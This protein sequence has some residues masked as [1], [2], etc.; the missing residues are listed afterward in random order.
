MSKKFTI[1]V[2][3]AAIG[4]WVPYNKVLIILL[5]IYII[6]IIKNSIMS[7]DFTASIVCFAYYLLNYCN[8]IFFKLGTIVEYI[9]LMPTEG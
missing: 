6:F 1:I 2:F 9:K 3:I 4:Y 5:L 8:L 7:E